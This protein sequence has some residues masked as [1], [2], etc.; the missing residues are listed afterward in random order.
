VVKGPVR[1]WGS[2]QGNRILEALRR[3]MAPDPISME[4][5]LCRIDVPVAERSENGGLILRL[6]DVLRCA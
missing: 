4:L 1:R 6:D 3:A 5:G 2:P